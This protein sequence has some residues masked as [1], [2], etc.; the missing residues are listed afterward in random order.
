M[1]NNQPEQLARWLSRAQQGGD[2]ARPEGRDARG[3][4]GDGLDADVVE[5]L[6]ALRPDLAPPPRVCIDD[7]LAAVES[8]PL[9]AQ[10][11][12]A[13][14]AALATWLEGGEP[15]D[16]GDV[17]EAIT[18]LRP[19][20]AP[21]P[22]VDIDDILGAVTAGP[23]AASSPSAQAAPTE[24]GAVISLAARRPR[25][26][27]WALP[28][29]GALAAAAAALLVVQ[30]IS[31]QQLEPP[32]QDPVLECAT[33]PRAAPEA[34]SAP[35]AQAPERIAAAPA[36]SPKRKSEAQPAP[37]TRTATTS[38]S[39]DLQG[40][41]VAPAEPSREQLQA[42]GYVGEGEDAAESEEPTAQPAMRTPSPE[43]GVMDE[44]RATRNRDDSDDEGMSSSAGGSAFDIAS[45]EES[46]PRADAPVAADAAPSI[47]SPVAAGAAPSIEEPVATGA[48]PSIEEPV[49]ADAEESAAP[50]GRGGFSLPRP[51]KGAAPAGAAQPAADALAEA[52]DMPSG[53][54]PIGQAEV[55]SQLRS[56]AFSLQAVPDVAGRYPEV[57]EA[58]AMADAHQQVNDPA[59][60][61]AALSSLTTHTDPDVVLD[62]A[63]RRAQLLLRMGRTPAA[64]AAVDQGLAVGGGDA[65]LRSRLL[66][67]RGQL[68]ERRG[69]PESAAESYREAIEVR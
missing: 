45:S 50:R 32:L 48:A 11:A 64:Q 58:Y 53:L 5:A 26:L 2:D 30:P 23:F 4:D 57:A 51:R 17:V 42:L 56:A 22:Q 36:A 12:L 6:F 47:D 18:A 67:L 14:G 10:E 54:P 59:S 21:P 7:I 8:G 37:S 41:I 13:D 3:W 43:T 1:S 16:D 25:K 33:A 61:L 55:L 49:A 63:W 66:A 24:G 31:L 38:S 68:L 44:L 65:L 69:D 27:W 35:A 9:L 60:A 28:G 62:V 34:P 40:G 20:L 46:A 19:A 29:L 39:A 15:P 52:A